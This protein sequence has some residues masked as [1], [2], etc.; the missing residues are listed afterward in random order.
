[1]RTYGPPDPDRYRPSRFGGG[2][3]I[4]GFSGIDPNTRRIVVAVLSELAH[5]AAHLDTA[6]EVLDVIVNRARQIRGDAQPAETPQPAAGP[7]AV[8]HAGAT[9]DGQLRTV[10]VGPPADLLPELQHEVIESG[11]L[12]AIVVPTDAGGAGQVHLPGDTSSW[13]GLVEAGQTLHALLCG[14][15]AMGRVVRVD[16]DGG[17]TCGSC[18]D[19][20]HRHVTQQ[21]RATDRPTGVEYR[22]GGISDYSD[23]VTACCGADEWR[24]AGNGPGSP[25]FCR[26]CG[27][28]R[29]DEPPATQVD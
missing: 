3:G 5:D 22:A 23:H 29:P 8:R 25:W 4:A 10:D 20:A 6:R 15:T 1:M 21:L 9:R 27:D 26:A 24:P 2:Q 13:S 18:A 16:P 19:V 28:T 17:I 11:Q 14:R 7:P 12:V